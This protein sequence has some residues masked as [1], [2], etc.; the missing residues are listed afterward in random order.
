MKRRKNNVEEIVEK[1]WHERDKY[2]SKYRHDENKTFNIVDELKTYM[3][4]NNIDFKI[5][6]ENGYDSPGYSNDFMAIA[7]K[8]SNGNNFGSQLGL[9]TVVFEYM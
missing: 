2:Y 4:K 9:K 5:V 3:E 8:V 1:Y 6:K 7:Y